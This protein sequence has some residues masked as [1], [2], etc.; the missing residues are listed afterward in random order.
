M[1]IFV[2]KTLFVF[3]C[4]FLLF[5]LTFGAKLR[6]IEGQLEYFKS[7]ENIE[8]VKNKIRDELR[9]AIEKENYLDD[10]DAQLINEFVNKIKIELSN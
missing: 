8:I 10:E 7:K 5:H 1:K 3:L 6:E 2:Y 4:V 9:S